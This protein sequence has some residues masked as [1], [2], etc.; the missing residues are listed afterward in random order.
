MF[1]LFKKKP[2]LEVTDIVWKNDSAKQN[3]ILKHISTAERFILYYYFQDTKETFTEILRNSSISFADQVGAPEKLVLL[4]AK[5]PGNPHSIN[6]RNV[7]FLEHHPSFSAE[8]PILD[9]LFMAGVKKVLFFN[10]LKEPIFQFFGSERIVL[11]LEKMGLEEEESIEH[12]MISQSIRNAQQ[13]MDEKVIFP[14]STRNAKDW[15][16]SN[17]GNIKAE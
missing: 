13:K 15:I 11:L 12:P 4:Q 9:D 6:D 17:V 3:G 10:S 16:S 7:F 8:K 5:H 2:E 1:G 14:S